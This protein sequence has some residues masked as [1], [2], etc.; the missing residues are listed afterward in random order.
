MHHPLRTNANIEN[1]FLGEIKIVRFSAWMK[2]PYW[3]RWLFAMWVLACVFYLWQRSPQI[4]HFV[5]ADTDDNMRLLQARAWVNGQD[6]YDLRQYKMLAPEGAN[7]HWSRWVDI[8]LAGLILLFRVFTDNITAERYACALAPLLPLYVIMLGAALTVR[9][10]FAPWMWC[11][12]AMLV[13]F[14]FSTTNMI[15]PMRIDHHG[16]QL[17]FLALSMAGLVDHNPVRGGVTL[18]LSSALSLSIGL[19]L[20][21]YLAIMGAGVGLRWITDPS[22][23]ARLRSYGFALAGGTAVAY[24]LF[25][26]YDNAEYRCDAL[27][28]IWLTVMSFVGVAVAALSFIRDQ[29][30]WV[31]LACAAIV[32]VIIA[33]LFATNYPQCLSRPEDISDEAQRLWLV[34]VKEAKSVFD[35]SLPTML[36]YI[37]MPVTGL[38]GFLLIVIQ[39]RR[40]YAWV[41]WMPFLLVSALSF[42]LLLWQTRAAGSAGLVSLV[43][44][45][46]LVFITLPKIAALKKLVLRASAVLALLIVVTGMGGRMIIDALPA[47]KT[48]ATKNKGKDPVAD[49]SANCPTLAALKPIAALPKAT[50]FTLVDLAPRLTTMTHHNSITGPYHRNDDAIA[51]VFKAF[52]GTPAEAE[53]YVR[54]YRADY[55]LICPDYPEATQHAASAPNGF[56]Q[57]LA[58][59]QT[60]DWLEP[61]PLPNGSFYRLWKVKP[62]A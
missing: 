19:E 40:D 50:I 28:P 4:A 30:F 22:D 62:D 58:K 5:L 43:G 8:P 17:A 31:R 23:T 52:R 25:A 18:A 11:V 51:N 24:L 16:W 20:L 13:F 44:I 53:R 55:V 10:L 21:P 45:S 3:L 29:R 37:L 2:D 48:A 57:Q 38:I 46:A 39:K 47:E 61:V 1:I 27:T 33:A 9:R 36:G 32:G 60:P 12:G 42:I 14:S 56:H 59:G 49:A 54:Q 34:N 41:N 15:L 35:Q 26:S 7:M 6:W